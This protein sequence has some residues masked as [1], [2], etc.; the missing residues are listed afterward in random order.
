M[1]LRM[2]CGIPGSGKSTLVKRLPGYVVS[3]DS[4]RRFLWQDEAVIKHDSLVF[5]LA[6]NIVEYLLS[7]KEDVIFD[8]TNLTA[9]KRSNFVNLAKKTKASVDL[10]W[11]NCLLHIAIKRNSGRERKVPEKII[12]SLYKSFQRPTAEEGFD[13]IKV[14]GHDLNLTK[15]ILPG[16]SIKR[17]R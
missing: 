1:K 3:T 4:I 13:A 12:I 17:S 8:A 15:V 10:H 9:A 11:V 7:R 2:L 16:I 6:E 5:S 14:Y